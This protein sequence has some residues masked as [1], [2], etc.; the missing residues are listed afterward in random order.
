[1]LLVP[2]VLPFTLL[3]LLATLAIAG[4]GAWL[5]YAWFAGIVAGTAYLV[6]GLALLAWSFVGRW[7]VLLFAGRRG[8]DDPRELDSP[9][10]MDVERPDGTV[11]RVQTYG[12]DA[13]QAPSIVFTHGW[14]M[15]N[16][17]WY[18]LKRSLAGRFR[19]ITWDLRGLGGSSRPPNH[20]FSLETMARDLY[21][22]VERAAGDRPVVLAGHSIGGMITLTFCRL[23]QP[24]L[25]RRVAGL[26]LINTTYTNPVRTTS[27][28]GFF[29]AIQRPILEPLLHVVTWISPLVWAMSWLSYLNGSAH[30]VSALTG[31]AGT[32]SRGQLEFVTRLSNHGAPAS[33]ARGVLAMFRYD[34][35]EVLPAIDVPA[36]VVT[37]DLDRVLVPEASA[38]MRDALPHAELRPLS[39]AGHM[40]TL[41]RHEALAQAIEGFVDGL[42]RTPAARPAA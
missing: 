5:V 25:R 27:F 40:S 29:S 31:F 4:S 22:V 24:E 13:A 41:E 36:L 21:A 6:G 26:V 38:A 34:A 33:L 3:V 7:I 9:R 39:P 35:S 1:M 15:S 20:D 28:S 32:Q 30:I 42:A 37:G 14:G 18:Y 2:P 12:P 11:L 10:L 17:E 16:A 8:A 19:L 23:F